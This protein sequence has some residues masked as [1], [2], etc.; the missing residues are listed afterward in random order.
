MKDKQQGLHHACTNKCVHAH[1][2]ACTCTQMQNWQLTIQNQN[3]FFLVTSHSQKGPS[4]LYIHEWERERETNIVV[5][6]SNMWVP[7]CFLSDNTSAGGVISL[8]WWR[9]NDLSDC[10]GGKWQASAINTGT[11]SLFSL[12]GRS[13]RKPWKHLDSFPAV[14]MNV[15]LIHPHWFKQ[16]LIIPCL[17]RPSEF[18]LG[19]NAKTQRGVH[20]RL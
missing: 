4:W 14:S 16:T 11:N 9:V 12:C 10:L 5:N 13:C 8:P 17:W 7:P 20:V 15:L 18:L 19:P 2:Q 3:Y 1:T 6:L